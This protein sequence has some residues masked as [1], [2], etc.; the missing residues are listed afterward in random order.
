MT[1]EQIIAYVDGEL[2]PI[3]AMRFER[4][5]EAD[6]VLAVEVDRHRQ[7]R[8]AVARH[9]APIAEAPLPERLSALLDR[10]RNVVAFR[11]PSAA[12]RWLRAEGRYAALAATL[13]AGLAIGQLLP[14]AGGRQG[15]AVMAQG[16]LAIALERQLASVKQDGAYR[17]GTT[18]RTADN[19]Y[20]RTF[21][22]KAGAG[23]GCHGDDGWALARF[24]AG[25]SSA[26]GGEYRQASSVSGEIAAAAQEMMAGAPLD[27]EAE[28]K[29]R[30]GG[31]PA[32][33]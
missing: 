17:I 6:P 27:A 25:G 24:V 10:G 13:V 15:G 19:R 18:F 8:E 29:A 5:M 1:E 2:G 28:R 20:C 16:D 9:F 22:G 14:L 30:D 26:P 11:K 21:S 31:W 7:V 33:P 32:R 3:D 12:S 4:A 23:I